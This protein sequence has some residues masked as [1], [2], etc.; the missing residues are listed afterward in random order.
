MLT[1]LKDVARKAGA[2]LSAASRPLGGRRAAHQ[3][4]RKNVLA[5]TVRLD[6]RPNRVARGFVTGQ[7]RT[8]TLGLVVGGIRNPF[9]ADVAR[10]AEDAAWPAGWDVVLCNSDLDPDKQMRCVRSL[11]EKSS[12]SILTRSV[13]CL[14]R[15]RP[16]ELTSLRLPIGLL[17][18]GANAQTVSSVCTDSFRDRQLAAECLTGLG[19]RRLDRLPGPRH[20]RNFAECERGMVKSCAAAADLH[21]GHNSAGGYVMARRLFERRHVE[22]A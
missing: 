5:V 1:S 15:P 16:A 13:A 3:E 20:H 12:D 11:A 7:S 8:H 14:N 18:R 22:L 21:G 6:R 9:F 17:A 19:H 4:T 2:N 10:G